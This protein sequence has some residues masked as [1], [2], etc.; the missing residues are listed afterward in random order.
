MKKKRSKSLVQGTLL[1]TGAGALCKVLGMVYRIHLGNLLGTQGMGGYQLVYS[2]YSML[3]MA[4]SGGI[5]VALSAVVAGQ[6]AGHRPEEAGAYFRAARGLT[7]LLGL[8]FGA[9]S[10]ALSAALA[11]W[12]GMPAAEGSL[13]IAAPAILFAAVSAAYRGYY[14]GAQD[15]RP[16]AVSQIVEQVVK[17]LAGAYFARRWSLRGTA[18]GVAGAMF[19]V[20]RLHPENLG[21]ITPELIVRC[22]QSCEVYGSGV[23]GRRCTDT[24]KTI[25][26]ADYFVHTLNRDEIILVET[27][28]VFRRAEIAEAYEAAFRDGFTGTDDA[29]LM[30]RI[31]KPVRLVESR[32]E[33][34]KLTIPHDFIRGERQLWESRQMRVGQGYDIHAL[35]PGRRLILGG[36]EIPHEKGLFGHSD[37]DVLTHALIDALLGAAALG[38]IGEWFPDTDPAYQGADSMLLLEQVREALEDK[39]WEILNIDATIFA[40]KPKLSPY[41]EGIRQNIADALNLSLE[42]VNIK[43]KTA[44]KFGAVGGGEAIAAAVSCALRKR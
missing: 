1:L 18:Y 24:V 17:M 40:E 35:V 27:P 32:E 2:V 33:N 4:A 8:A 38:D 21:D 28:Q 22:V 30:E 23:A 9:A 34:F 41:K 5:S 37:A 12:V 6:L 15:M 11:R 26:A 3:L 31:G 14:Q 10:Y 25:D 36:V 44:E 16:A 20:S 43:A 13:K 29:G 7:V 19:G 39:F 42:Q